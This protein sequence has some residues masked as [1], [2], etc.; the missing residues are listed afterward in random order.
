MKVDK[1]KWFV[2]D[3]IDITQML[4]SKKDLT[5]DNNICPKLTETMMMIKYKDVKNEETYKVEMVDLYD[6]LWDSMCYALMS[7]VSKNINKIT[8][9]LLLHKALLNK[10]LGGNL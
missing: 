6:D 1:S 2:K 5:W 7:I 8:N 3:R 4:L 9:P 10:H